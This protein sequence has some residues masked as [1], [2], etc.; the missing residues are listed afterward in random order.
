[1]PLL[2]QTYHISLQLVGKPSRNLE[3]HQLLKSLVNRDQLTLGLGGLVVSV[4]NVEGAGTGLL[5][6]NNCVKTLADDPL[7]DTSIPNL[8]NMKLYCSS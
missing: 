8:P 3:L 2:S 6:A 7:Q 1:M 4:T 5:G